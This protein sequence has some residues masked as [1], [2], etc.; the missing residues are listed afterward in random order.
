[1]DVLDFKKEYKDLYAPGGI[2]TL[3]DVPAMRFIMVDGKGNP[4]D[5]EGEYSTAIELLYGLSYTIKMS[6]K[7]GP[8][9]KGYYEYVVPPLEGLWWLSDNSMDFVRKDK[10][11]WTSMIRQPD[12]VDEAVFE[13]AK[14]TFSRKKKNPDLS[15]VRFVTWQEGLCVQIMHIGPYE[16]EPASVAKIDAY[17]RENA[18]YDDIGETRRHHEI[19]LGDPRKTAPEK[20]KTIIRHPVRI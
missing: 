16:D 9:P 8:A 12:F 13:A 20:R 15:K 10:Y 18:L 5:E 14:E 2:P 1:M 11:L 17:I 4:N 3:I 6:P 7:S 19:Y